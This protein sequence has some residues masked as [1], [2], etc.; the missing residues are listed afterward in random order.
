MSKVVNYPDVFRYI[1]FN[2]LRSVILIY[3]YIKR[4]LKAQKKP[5][6]KPSGKFVI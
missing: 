4:H 6:E 2:I 3:I 1:V 5:P